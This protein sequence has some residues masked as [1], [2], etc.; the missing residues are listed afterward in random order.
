[1]NYF[2]TFDIL[3]SNQGGFRKNNSTIATTSHFLDDIFINI[4]NKKT[5][6]TVFIDFKKALDSVNHNIIL[7]KLKKLGLQL[8]TID[9][10]RSYLASRTQITSVNQIHPDIAPVTYCVPQGSIL[11]PLLFL[12]FIDDLGSVLQ[13]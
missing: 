1:M 7:K 6:L 4:N 10:F 5:T 13:K 11:G 8:N 3:D 12:V 2:N 9:W